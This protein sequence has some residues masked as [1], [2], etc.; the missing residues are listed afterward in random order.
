MSTI[1][2]KVLKRA[3]QKLPL[4]PPDAKKAIKA[5]T[6]SRVR[7]WYIAKSSDAYLLSFPKCGRTWLRIMLGKVI[8]LHYQLPEDV[9]LV[10]IGFLAS[11][12]PE[13]PRI[14][15]SHDE[16]PQ[17]KKPAELE[18]SKSQYAGKKVILLVRN[19]R[20]VLV[21]NYFQET[22]RE[23]CTHKDISA[24]LRAESGSV[25]T[26]LTWYNIWA[27]NRHLPSEFCLDQYENLH[28]DT[29]GELRKI[30]AILGME[31]VSDAHINE[32][33]HY[34]SFD[35]MRKL[36]KSDSCNSPKLRPTNID[37]PES[38]KTRRGKVGG[39]TDYLGVAD[40]EY[41]DQKIR[42]QLSDFYSSYK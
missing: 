20:D 7:S 11:I 36:E 41:V 3:L 29:L 16:G 24:Y 4:L 25:D 38:Y 1:T 39:F 42:N 26:L 33:I 12:N 21:S 8:Q 10:N 13:I 23:G 22:K 17:W 40:I 9:N 15:I 35:N 2:G 5:I 31:D 19:P 14:H 6:P 34:A 27:D 37:D 18:K 30:L 32:A 28:L